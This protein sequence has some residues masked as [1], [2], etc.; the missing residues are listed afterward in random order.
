MGDFI[1]SLI[2]LGQKWKDPLMLFVLHQVM[3]KH[4]KLVRS[5]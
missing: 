5:C 3:L 4:D 1:K 2:Y